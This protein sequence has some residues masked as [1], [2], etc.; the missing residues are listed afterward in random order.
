MIVTPDQVLLN[1]RVPALVAEWC[2]QRG[3][4]RVTLELTDDG[5][6]CWV[7]SGSATLE[8]DAVGVRR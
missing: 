3:E 4:P 7:K 2:F 5:I 1:P 8:F 6:N